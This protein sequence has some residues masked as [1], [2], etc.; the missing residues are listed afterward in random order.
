M[1]KKAKIIIMIEEANS[2]TDKPD[3]NGLLTILFQA[4]LRSI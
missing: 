2:K 1:V 3:E 4:N